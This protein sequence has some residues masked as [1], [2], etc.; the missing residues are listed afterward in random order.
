M[1]HKIIDRLIFSF[2][3]L[4]IKLS[5]FIYSTDHSLFYKNPKILMQKETKIL[6]ILASAL[7]IGYTYGF[8][9]AQAL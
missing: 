2:D 3:K 9:L 1:T 7:L 4:I 8:D 5:T 6:I